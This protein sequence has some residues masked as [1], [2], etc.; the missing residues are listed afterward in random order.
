MLGDFSTEY[1]FDNILFF[2]VQLQVDIYGK[3]FGKIYVS[4]YRLVPF[5]GADFF[6]FKLKY[7]SF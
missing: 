3:F 2:I 6:Q 4:S 1:S 7:T 5:L